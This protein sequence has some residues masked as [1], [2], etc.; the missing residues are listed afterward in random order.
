MEWDHI[1]LD[2][3][4]LAVSEARKCVLEK[5]NAP[6]VGA[7]ARLSDGS[8]HSAHRGEHVDAYSGEQGLGDHAEY[9]LLHKKLGALKLSGASVYATLE[10]CTAG[11]TPPKRP[12]VD[13]LIERRV[14]RLFIGMLDPDLRIQGHGWRKL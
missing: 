9:T 1:D 7:V 2:C 6:Y 12:C 3:M 11:R 4:K 5:A 13:W 10:P 8:I 14:S